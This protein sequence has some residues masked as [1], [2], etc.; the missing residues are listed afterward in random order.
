MTYSKE[1]LAYMVVRMKSTSS[2]LYRMATLIG[3]HAFIEFCGLM[4]EYIAMCETALK[5][6]A[7]FTEANVHGGPSLPMTPPQ[8]AYLG[9]KFGCI[10]GPTFAA[11]PDLLAIFNKAAFES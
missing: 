1:E 9:E 4:N 7:D 10:F 8:A 5:H 6:G 11:N 2:W 3:N